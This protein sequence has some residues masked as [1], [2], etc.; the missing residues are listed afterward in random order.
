[1]PKGRDMGRG[2]QMASPPSNVTDISKLIAAIKSD[3]IEAGI[4]DVPDRDW[5]DTGI[6]KLNRI[7]S[8]KKDLGLPIGTTIEISGDSQTGKS[9]L[10]GYLMGMIQ[11]NGGIVALADAE[12]AFNKEYTERVHGV[13]SGAIMFINSNVIEEIIS[14]ISL[15]VKLRK[16]MIESGKVKYEDLPMMMFFIDSFKMCISNREVKAGEENYGGYG[17][18]RTMAFSQEYPKVNKRLSKYRIGAVWINQ[19]R[20]KFGSFMSTK[21][22]AG[23]DAMRYY[24]GIRLRMKNLGRITKVKN[25]VKKTIGRKVEIECIKTR[26]TNPYGKIRVEMHHNGGWKMIDFKEKVSGDSDE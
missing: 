3:L 1:M 25:G 2:S 22:S 23:G 9:Y 8:G 21:E 18:A 20:T 13:N 5:V 11:R 16:K 15:T 17:T 7:I 14:I 26:H 6:P 10:M 19:L 12:N 24:P 4:K